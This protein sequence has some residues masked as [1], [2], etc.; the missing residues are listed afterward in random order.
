MGLYATLRPEQYTQYFLAKW[1]RERI[2]GQFETLKWIGWLI[3]GGCVVAI[4]FVVVQS[5]RA[6][7]LAS[8]GA[9]GAVLFLMFAA[10]WLWWGMSLLRRPDAFIRRTNAHLP[11]WIVIVFGAV[12]LLGGIHFGCQFIVRVRSLLR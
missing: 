2:S 9:L 3:F 10:A 8:G 1:Q 5:V 12:L 11:R 4:L 6:A 7:I